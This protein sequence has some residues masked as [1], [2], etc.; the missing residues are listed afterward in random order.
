MRLVVGLLLFGTLLCAQSVEVFSEFPRDP[1]GLPPPREIISPAVARNAFATFRV[2]VT[3]P[4]S[5][6]YFMFVGANPPG[7]VRTELFKEEGAYLEEVRIPPGFGVIPAWQ[8][9]REYILDVWVPAEAEPGRRVRI[10]V[11]LKTGTWLIYPMELRVQSAMA[12]GLVAT[13]LLSTEDLL[14]RNAAQDIAMLMRTTSPLPWFLLFRQAVPVWMGAGP[15][16]VLRFR[17]VLYRS[18]N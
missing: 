2:V 11:Q 15:E 8:T 7:I 10:E 4:A 1:E 12:P 9:T 13:P 16:W 18:Q 3:A 17:D 5:T 14:R 6:T